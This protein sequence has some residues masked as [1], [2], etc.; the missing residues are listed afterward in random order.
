M[1]PRPDCR[2]VML[3][4]QPNVAWRPGPEDVDGANATHFMNWLK[5]NRRINLTTWNDLWEWS[6]HDLNMFW[7]AVW[8]YYDVTADRRPDH[9]A[10]S[11]AMPHTR[12]FGGAQLNYAK[13]VL[14]RAPLTRPA[15]TEVREAT[16]P[17]E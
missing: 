10:T 8:D 13:N 12:W 4:Y 7:A 2:P 17:R 14:A 9:I 11:D 15:P 3:S 6:V 1:R 16:S 5:D